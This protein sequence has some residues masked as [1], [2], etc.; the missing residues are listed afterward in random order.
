MRG[1][2]IP[3]FGLYGDVPLGRAW[4]GTFDIHVRDARIEKTTE[5]EGNLYGDPL[6][7]FSRVGGDA[8]HFHKK[9]Q[10]VP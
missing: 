4:L 10:V 1:R 5:N 6:D 3:L 2:G 8:A 9:M 7:R